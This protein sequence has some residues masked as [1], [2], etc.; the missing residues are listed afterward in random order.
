MTSGRLGTRVHPAAPVG[1]GRA[2]PGAAPPRGTGSDGVSGSR[3]ASVQQSCPDA[4]SRVATPRRDQGAL[5]SGRPS[6][7]EAPRR[8]SGPVPLSDSLAKILPGSRAFDPAPPYPAA[9]P[10]VPFSSPD[11]NRRDAAALRPRRAGCPRCASAR[12]PNRRL[13]V[14]RCGPPK[15]APWVREPPLRAPTRSAP[16]PGKLRRA[17]PFYSRMLARIS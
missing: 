16:C 15:A 11:R 7:G 14:P 1:L 10:A 17:D 12:E 9:A 8:R 2:S 3:Q 6:P 4:C 13:V 5:A